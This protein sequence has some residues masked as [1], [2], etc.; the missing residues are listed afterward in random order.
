MLTEHKFCKLRKKQ[1]RPRTIKMDAE[2]PVSVRRILTVNRFMNTNHSSDEEH[3]GLSKKLNCFMEEPECLLKNNKHSFREKQLVLQDKLL[4]K[5]EATPKQV[6][7]YKE[8]TILVSLIWK[9]MNWEC[10]FIFKSLEVLL[11]WKPPKKHTAK[12]W[13][14]WSRF[15]KKL[16]NTKNKPSCKLDFN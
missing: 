10:L 6:F 13:L 2:V 1:R 16:C 4:K 3:Q 8:N 14:V 11:F 9:L 5:K 12:Q 15:L 7:H